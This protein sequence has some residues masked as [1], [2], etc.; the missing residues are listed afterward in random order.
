MI[1][2]IQLSIINIVI[3]EELAGGDLMKY[4]EIYHW[5]QNGF[6]AIN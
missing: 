6:Y 2:Y 1:E 5:I 4:S 3:A